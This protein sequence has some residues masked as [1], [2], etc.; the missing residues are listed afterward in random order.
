ME[1]GGMNFNY[2]YNVSGMWCDC[3]Q[4][5]GI[6]EHYGLTG[7]EAVPVLRKLREH[8]EDN[9][10]RLLEFEPSN[11]WGG[12]DGALDFVNRLIAASI[13]NPDEKWSGD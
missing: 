1:I 4:A 12:F 9:M 8:M 2:T 3:Y 7:K 11:G 13:A 5:S 10:D 6:R